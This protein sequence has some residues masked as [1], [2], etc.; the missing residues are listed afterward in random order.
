MPAPACSVDA[1]AACEALR[2]L[3]LDQW[4]EEQEARNASEAAASWAWPGVASLLLAADWPALAEGVCNCLLEA[5]AG[6]VAARAAMTRGQ[7][8]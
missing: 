5:A 7:Q 4:A 8:P 3:P 6:E 2:E 1:S